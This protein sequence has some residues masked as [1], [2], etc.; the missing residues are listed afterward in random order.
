MSDGWSIF[1][2]LMTEQKIFY[3]RETNSSAFR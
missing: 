1:D 2:S 3:N